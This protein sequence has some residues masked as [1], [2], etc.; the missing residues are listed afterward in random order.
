MELAAYR[1]RFPILEHTTYLINHSLGAMPAVAEER[2]AEYAR[3]WRERGIRAW[4][5]GWWEM[6]LTVG[7]Q[8]G[9]IIGAP[10][11]STVMHQNVAVAEAVVLSCFRP[12]DPHRNRVVYEEGNFPSVRYL[13]QAQ[14]E[15]E[16]VAVEDDAAI[17]DAIDERTLLVPISH[18][19]FKNAEI[20]E[21]EPIVRRAHEVGAYVVLDCYQSAGVVPFDVTALDVDFAVGGSVKWLCGGPG[22]GWLYV[23][24]DLADRL[25]PTFVGWQ[26]HAR[27]FAFEP[28]L[29]YAAGVRRFLTGT[30][31]VPA[32]YAATAGYDVIEEVGV[33]RIRG[34][35]LELTQLLIDL[36]E[37]SGFEIG[38]PRDP[39][40]RGGTVL[41]RTPDNPAVHREL[42]ERGIICDFRPDAGIRLGPHFY[43]SEDE[44]RHTVEQLTEIVATGAY[45]RHAGAAARF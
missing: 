12:V 29:E 15:L 13:Y 25:E 9:R 18:V 16:I 20:Q 35:S 44:L 19:L 14:P 10:P 23:R 5:E 39:E 3:M 45:A 37:D 33:Q 21:V 34:R 42:G 36:L 31:N 27:P 38:S 41:V 43:N 4:A 26:G 40:R 2:L 22:A 7:D 30:P 11:G 32:L 1:D 8:I 6:P 28:E 24:P 17:V